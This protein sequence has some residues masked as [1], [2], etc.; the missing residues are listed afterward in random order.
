MENT[1]NQD[2]HVQAAEQAQIQLKLQEIIKVLFLNE[3]L[4]KEQTEFL[5]NYSESLQKYIDA[6]IN[7]PEDAE[8]KKIF[9]R[10]LVLAKQKG[11]LPDKLEPYIPT[12]ETPVNE[13]EEERQGRIYE[14]A[15]TVAD[16]V[17]DGL[18]KVKIPYHVNQGRMTPEQA[19][20]YFVD[21]A[22]V[23]VSNFADKVVDKGI[24]WAVNKGANY[25]VKVFPPAAPVI[26]VAKKAL[27]K[28]R[29]PVKK[30]VRTGVKVVAEGAK[31]IAKTVYN[32]G[33]SV[34]NTVVS[35]GKKLWG[36]VKGIFS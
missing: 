17:D 15:Q 20:D 16:I 26:I 27:Q 6:P 19:I 3:E 5:Q 9:A 10:V 29:E 7:S 22:A 25:L 2:T 36:F 35:T 14:T 13:T 28:F 11:I 18:D 32:A 21:K 23:K 30:A 4:D 33:K 1:Y 12:V 24:D 31:T 8:T 34:V